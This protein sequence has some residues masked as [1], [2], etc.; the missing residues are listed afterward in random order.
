MISECWS[1]LIWLK[2]IFKVG[3]GSGWQVWTLST[4]HKCPAVAPAGEGKQG[5][6]A[7]SLGGCQIVRLPNSNL[8]YPDPVT[9]LGR[10]IIKSSSSNLDSPDSLGC[11][12]IKLSNS[13]LRCWRST[14]TLARRLKNGIKN[15]DGYSSHMYVSFI[16]TRLFFAG[17]HSDPTNR[18][19]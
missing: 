16:K 1:M 9:H 18:R 19:F 5:K 4:F 7:D 14:S 12:I 2:L 11:Q 17:L 13:N 6:P 10:R 15:M 3:V 8:D